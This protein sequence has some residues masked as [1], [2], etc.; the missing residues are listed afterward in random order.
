MIRS[1]MNFCDWSN[2]TKK[3]D[4][5]EMLTFCSRFSHEMLI[6]KGKT[7]GYYYNSKAVG[8]E[9]KHALLFLFV[10]KLSRALLL[11]PLL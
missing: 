11:S 6:Y 7:L 5:H 4:A 9:K 1:E 3:R 10:R 8:Q 2:G